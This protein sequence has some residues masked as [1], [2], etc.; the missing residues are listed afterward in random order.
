VP[1]CPPGEIRNDNGA[2]EP[3]RTPSCPPGE[4]RDRDGRCVGNVPPL[5]PPPPQRLT[6]RPELSPRQPPPPQF[7]PRGH[8][9]SGGRITPEPHRPPPQR[10]R[11]GEFRR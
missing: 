8:G 10:G 6:P 2:C 5:P 7:G 1:A 9:G 11:G 4:F 3:P